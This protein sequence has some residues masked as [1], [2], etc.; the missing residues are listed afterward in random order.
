MWETLR[1]EEVLIKL[2]TS[3][4]EGL[5]KEEVHKRQQKY[6]KNKLQERNVNNLFFIKKRL[7]QKIKKENEFRAVL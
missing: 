3:K 2:K 5:S 1:K 7:P 6:G 4:K